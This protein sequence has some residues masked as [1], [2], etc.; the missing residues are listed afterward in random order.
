MER[1][2]FGP[3]WMLG[4]RDE[5]SLGRPFGPSLGM[6]RNG[7]REAFGGI[8]PNG[9]VIG[10]R[11]PP[12]QGS[13]AT[14]PLEQQA[15]GHGFSGASPG[16]GSSDQSS[17]RFLDNVFARW[18]DSENREASAFGDFGFTGSEASGVSFGIRC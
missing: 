5:V 10:E 11:S 3:A 6:R 1:L 17:D 9:E 2:A 7:D 16:T 8:G 15:F 13:M 12:G 14:R 4:N 18:L